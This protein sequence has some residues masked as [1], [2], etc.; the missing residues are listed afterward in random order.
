MYATLLMDVEDIVAPESDDIAAQ[1]ADI[2][3]EESLP[4]TFCIVGDKVRQMEQRNRTDVIASLAKMDIGTHTDFHSAHPTILEYLAGKDWEAGVEEA[5]RQEKPA[6]DA[7]ERVFGVTPSCWGGPGNNWGCQINGAMKAL[8]IPAVVYSY[9]MVPDGQV[10]RFEGVLAY[11]NGRYLHDGEYQDSDFVEQD[12]QRLSAELESDRQ[13]GKFWQQIFVGHPT[14]ILHTHFWDVPLFA[15]GANPPRNEWIAAERK[16]QAE[17]DR[18]MENFRKVLR[19]IKALPGIEF[20][21]IREMNEILADK[22][23][24]PLS[25]TD[26]DAVWSGIERRMNGM[27]KWPVLPQNYNVAS[28]IAV[29]RSRMTNLHTIALHH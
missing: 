23:T 27:A 5:I 11:P 13:N 6:I 4:A 22:P 2:F 28:H 17:L 15:N 26:Q 8:N 24:T 25:P 10:H 1:C 16:P 7:I 14:R 18:A 29:M 9:T 21:T 3:T 19:K 12:F 20:K